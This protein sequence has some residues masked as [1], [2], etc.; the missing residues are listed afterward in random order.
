MAEA[1][2]GFICPMCMADLKGENQLIVHFDEKHSREDPEIVKSFKELFIKAKKKIINK[3]DQEN[4]QAPVL[5]NTDFSKEVYGK[6]SSLYHP[7]SGIHKDILEEADSDIQVF[8]K[9]DQFREERA[10]R[11]DVRTMDINKFIVR[12]EKLMNQLPSDPVKRRNHEQKVVP[13]INEKDVPRC[14]ECA[15]SFNMMKRRHHCR[16]CGGVMCEDCSDFVSF[17]LAERLINPATISKFNQSNDAPKTSPNKSKAQ[18]KKDELITNLLDFAGFGEDQRSFRSCKLCKEVL[19]KRDQRLRIKTA[20]D[21]DLVRY[22]CHLQK[23]LSQGEEMSQKYH[24]MADS[25]NNGES[26]YQIKEAQVLRMQVMKVA[27]TVPVLAKKIEE[28]PP[29][30]AKCAKLQDRIRAA[31]MNFVKETLVGLPPTPTEAEFEDIKRQKAHEAAKRIEEEKKSALE[32]KIKSESLKKNQPFSKTHILDAVSKKQLF[33]VT[34]N[35]A[36]SRQSK[37]DVKIIGQ[38]FVSTAGQE[39]VDDDPLGQQIHNLKQFIKQA[40]AAGKFDDARILENNLKDF[41]EEHRR[42][43]TELQQNYEEFKGLFSKPPTSTTNVTAHPVNNV[44][45]ENDKTSG[46]TNSTSE[47]LDESNPFFDAEEEQTDENNP[48]KEESE[49]LDHYDKSGKNPFD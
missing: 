22:Y 9:F 30:D 26:T 19:D 18:A 11:V 47:E 32:A 29:D 24:K 12:L 37:K 17:E 33:P 38:G 16:L 34:G 43:T 46:G 31:A 21:P 36:T 27:E 20:P 2:E 45:V 35:G 15:S 25:L 1:L 41:Q 14:P 39:T 4:E 8:D 10:K 23:L 40:K 3:N 48:F 44:N 6:E 5:E 13:W 42:Q 28:L 7:V 49:N